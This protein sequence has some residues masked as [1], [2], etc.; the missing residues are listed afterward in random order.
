MQYDINKPLNL[1]DGWGTSGFTTEIRN[2]TWNSGALYYL[3]D[4]RIELVK[5]GTVPEPAVIGLLALVALFLRR[6]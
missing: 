6:K 4:W 2:Y 5:A 1:S 3:D